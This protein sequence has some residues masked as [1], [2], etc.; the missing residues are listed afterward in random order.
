[1]DWS[2][3]TVVILTC[4][5][6]EELVQLCRAGIRRFWGNI[7]VAVMLDTDR[8]TETAIPDDVREVVRRL[9]YLRKVF[10]LPYIAPT[11]Q[12]YCIDSDCLLYAE[13]TDW[14]PAMHLGLRGY[15][16][17]EL[18]TRVWRE[19]GYLFTR[20]T[21]RFC[22]G[23]WSAK[24]SEMFEPN[25]DLAIRYVRQCMK[26]GFDK[27]ESAPIICEQC[28]LAGLW[29]MTYDEKL[30]DENKYPLWIPKPGMV[31]YHLS[32]A[33]NVNQGREMMSAYRELVREELCSTT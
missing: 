7:N 31:L 24:R 10:D 2:N 13:P 21:P 19:I 23:C 16:D 1:M 11:D 9:P 3:A 6:D 26:R 27:H 33:R 4:K 5:R 8:A 28:L 30:L 32:D 17:L 25:R 29:R 14:G 15:C 12:L 18:G 20:D 22:G